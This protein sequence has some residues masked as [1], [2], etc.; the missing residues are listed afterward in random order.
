MMDGDLLDEL[1]I[2]SRAAR[3]DAF[4]LYVFTIIKGC[5]KFVLTLR[6]FELMMRQM[7]Q[8]LAH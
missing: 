1:G 8:C 7:F 2:Y 6:F 3:R 5:V 4:T